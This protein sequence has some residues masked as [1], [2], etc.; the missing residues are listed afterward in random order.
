MSILRFRE[1]RRRLPCAWLLSLLGVLL[2]PS[3][4]YTPPDLT[5]ESMEQHERDSLAY[6]YTRHY[7]WN[8]NLELREDSISIAYLPVKE[9]YSFLHKG[10][11]VVVA[12]FAVHPEDN[13]D[14]VWVKLA[15]SQE[16]QGWIS[17]HELLRAFVPTDAISQTLYFFTHTRF[18]V[19]ILLFGFVVAAALFLAVRAKRVPVS[20]FAYESL[21]P[22]S[23]C[24]LTAIVAACYKTMRHF[25]PD[26]WLHY[27]FNPTLSPFHVPFTLSLFLAGVWLIL[28]VLLAVLDDLFRR[29]HP[30]EAMARLLALASG[31]ILC[32]FFFLLTIPIYI[33]YLVL[34]LFVWFFFKRLYGVLF[35]TRYRC[36]RCGHP[37]RAKG[38]CPRCGAMNE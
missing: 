19:Y 17:E 13:V 6:L 18:P 36:G 25:Y 20:F 38:V 24:L 22:L 9:Q 12:E 1:M 37:L 10:D 3:C 8:T 21:Y 29:L 32:Y 35:L 34:A 16:E 14:T 5:D 11:K 31:C 4:R 15:H 23:L 30:V 7:T 27:Y 26:V 33:G 28:V 2:F